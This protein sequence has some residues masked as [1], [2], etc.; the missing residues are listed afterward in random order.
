MPQR[1]RLSRRRGW[2]KPPSAVVVARP[3][4]W[5]NPFVIDATTSRAEAIARFAAALDAGDVGYTHDDVV[6]E[7]AGHDLACW[8]PL[9]EPCHADVLLA[10]AN[11]RPVGSV[12]GRS[13]R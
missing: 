10:V 13:R 3:S 5:G 1:I 8:C 4:R 11:E 9:D 12:R 2:R 6:R 7:L